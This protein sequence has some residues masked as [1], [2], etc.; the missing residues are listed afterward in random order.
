MLCASGLYG[1]ATALGAIDPLA[2]GYKVYADKYLWVRWFHRSFALFGLFGGV[3]GAVGFSGLCLLLAGR[4]RLLAAVGALLA[5]AASAVVLTVWAYDTVAYPFG[6][7]EGLRARLLPAGLVGF[8]LGFMILG[9]AALWVRGLGRWRY[10]VLA[11]GLG[12][13]FAALV[14]VVLL[15]SP[16]VYSGSYE[17]WPLV[18]IN[19]SRPLW[20]ALSGLGWL[21]L[22][23]SSGLPV[24][25]APSS[26]PRTSPWPAASTTA[27]GSATI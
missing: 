18:T 23:R 24:E 5:V 20:Q 3:L 16:P 12:G 26:R 11:L 4:Q 2:P 6:L 8:Y 19:L 1:L 21:L 22:A 14:P 10:A 15:V 7:S 27:P 9:A 25:N 17:G 13:M